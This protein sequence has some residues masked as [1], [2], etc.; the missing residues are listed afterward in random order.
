MTEENCNK[1]LADE[2]RYMSL[3]EYNTQTAGV[4]ESQIDSALFALC[5]IHKKMQKLHCSEAA[6]DDPVAI[7]L[8]SFSSANCRDILSR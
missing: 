4:D 2:R 1:L 7:P 6:P 8:E 3:Y 5:V